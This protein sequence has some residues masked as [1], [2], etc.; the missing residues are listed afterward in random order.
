MY[1]QYDILIIFL[2]PAN[3][4]MYF[5]RRPISCNSSSHFLVFV[6]SHHS[7]CVVVHNIDVGV[8][9]I[10]HA[11]RTPLSWFVRTTR[12]TCIGQYILK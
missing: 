12:L 6:N 10:V 2:D 8:H 4:P 11:V 3:E 1:M 7:Q 5:V 9:S